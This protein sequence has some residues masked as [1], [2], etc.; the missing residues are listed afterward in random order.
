MIE[1]LPAE[2]VVDQR[3]FQYAVSSHTG[4]SYSN[5]CSRLIFKI[6]LKM[7]FFL[8]TGRASSVVTIYESGGD[9]FNVD[10][11]KT[12]CKM[13][14]RIVRATPGFDNSCSCYSPTS[15]VKACGPSLSLGNYIASI[16]KRSSCLDITPADVN[17][18]RKLLEDCAPAYF[19]GKLAGTRECAKK[20]DFITNVFDLLV[21]ID[22]MRNTKVLKSTI[23]LS[24]KNYDPVFARNIFDQ[25]LSSDR[26]EQSGVKLV[27][28]KF[29]DFKYD[30]FHR[31]ILA[32]AIFPTIGLI[33]VAI[34]L[35]LYTQ[36]LVVMALTISSIITS[37]FI[38]Y[39][40]YHQIFRL[41]F[42]PFLNIMTFIFLVGIGADDAFVFNDAW[43]QAK[44]SLP[45]GSVIDWIEYTLKHAALSMFVSSFTTSAAFYA[46]VVSDITSIRL[47]GIFA[48]TSILIM[49]SLM[50]TWFPAGVVFMEKRR[51]TPN[52]AARVVAFRENPVVEIANDETPPTFGDD[53][54]SLPNN[55]PTKP[56][57]SVG[58]PTDTSFMSTIKCN[59]PA[60]PSRCYSKVRSK[61]SKLIR[62]LF[63]KWI[64]TSLR[65]YPIWLAALLALGIGMGWA[66]MV[67][68]GLQRPKS[69]DFQ[70][71]LS[72]HI[73][74]QYDLKYKNRFR[75]EGLAEKR[76]YVYIIFGF[77][78]E[79]N[80]NYLDPT[81]YGELQYDKSF[82]ILQPRAQKWFFE[83]L[84]S[85][86]RKQKFFEQN[87]SWNCFPEVIFRPRIE[88]Q[89]RTALGL[90]HF[91]DRKKIEPN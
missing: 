35:L 67:S 86:I 36:S 22:F 64:P 27:A 54:Q 6:S 11:L 84:C 29:H 66:A 15:S 12:I 23:V 59:S 75:F 1:D 31:K 38:A 40:I 19:A 34:I 79:D 83:D 9:L 69:S 89:Y 91:S 90:M 13:E 37:V 61:C 56:S 62:N 49:Y 71:F 76:F 50:I 20:R 88:L 18:A 42:F 85:N 55:D 5:Q 51:H 39:F 7:L 72:S 2:N 26:P 53:D 68:P 65:G 82:D 44:L 25:H 8:C 17:Y 73:L 46:N 24:P 33:M 43:S 14:E 74:E 70:L 80:G 45:N 4:T 10:D 3:R 81:N 87:I 57:N 47:F 16:R 60:W 41:T 30:E 21:D 58:N 28:F 63:K 77:K 52:V 78:A 48:G 32:D